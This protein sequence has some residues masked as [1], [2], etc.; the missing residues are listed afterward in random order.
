MIPDRPV[1]SAGFEKRSAALRHWRQRGPHQR[2]DD[3][4]DWRKSSFKTPSRLCVLSCPSSDPWG[5]QVPL[6]S[7]G[8]RV[9]TYNTSVKGELAV[10]LLYREWITI[11]LHFFVSLYILCTFA[12][13]SW[14]LQMDSTEKASGKVWIW[15][16]FVWITV[17][18]NILTE[19]PT[20][21]STEFPE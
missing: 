20:R 16:C 3:R 21:V 4:T 17:A 19:K 5:F 7:G 1:R 14:R 6:F 11:A 13:T 18:P 12:V 8:G 15:W 9:N 2:L 10:V